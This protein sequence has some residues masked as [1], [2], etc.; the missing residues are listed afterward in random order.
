MQIIGASLI[1][2]KHIVA[3]KAGKITIIAEGQAVPGPLHRTHLVANLELVDV[4]KKQEMVVVMVVM[5][6]VVKKKEESN[7]NL[8]SEHRPSSFRHLRVFW[9]LKKVLE[10]A[11]LTCEQRSST[12][13]KTSTQINQDNHIIYCFS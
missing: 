6:D 12:T 5:V 10:P 11:A 13:I 7:N 8:A 2:A 3:V 9:R 4:V 1:I